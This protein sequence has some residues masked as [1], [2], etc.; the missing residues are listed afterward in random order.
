MPVLP[1]SGAILQEIAKVIVGMQKAIAGKTFA[2]VQKDWIKRRMTFLILPKPRL[3]TSVAWPLAD[4]ERQQRVRYRRS[5]H[6]IHRTRVSAL[7][8][9]GAGAV[10]HQPARS[11]DRASGTLRDSRNLPIFASFVTVGGQMKY[12]PSL[13]D[14]FCQTG[15]YVGQVIKALSRLTCRSC[16]R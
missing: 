11:S 8:V 1:K 2:D 12:G 13:A 16:C 5:L 10:F 14:A 7:L 9:V 15:D 6:D 4:L 3:Q